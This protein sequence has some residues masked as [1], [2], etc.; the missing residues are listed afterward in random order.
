M[1]YGLS[2][3][4]FREHFGRNSDFGF[5]IVNLNHWVL[6]VTAASITI[7]EAGFYLPESAVSCQDTKTISSAHRR[8]FIFLASAPLKVAAGSLGTIS[9]EG[10]PQFCLISITVM[11]CRS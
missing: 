6:L 9:R 2:Q 7:T 3:F 11:Q 1:R 5:G 10:K 4:I 8:M